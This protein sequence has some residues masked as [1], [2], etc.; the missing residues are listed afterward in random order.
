M[1]INHIKLNVSLLTDLYTNT[2]IEAKDT[3][4]SQLSK[5]KLES[6]WKYVGEN[7][8]NILMLVSYPEQDELSNEQFS[9]LKS[10]LSACKIS[11]SDVVVMNLSQNTTTDYKSLKENFKSQTIFLFGIEPSILGMPL[12]FP[13]FQVQSFDHCTFLYSPTLDELEKDKVLKSKIWV[14]LRRIF[15]I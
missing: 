4:E 10:L 12:N 13:Q 3:V 9:F 1:N 11:L 14:C 15:S 8:K 6:S 5:K 2:L 7:E